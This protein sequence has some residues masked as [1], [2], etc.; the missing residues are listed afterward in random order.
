MNLTVSV[1]KV[2]IFR[3]MHW[4]AHF[5]FSQAAMC[6]GLKSVGTICYRAYGSRSPA[7]HRLDHIF[8]RGISI[9]CEKLKCAL[10]WTKRAGGICIITFMLTI[11]SDRLGTCTISDSL[12]TYL[13]YHHFLSE[14]YN[15]ILQKHCHFFEAFTTKFNASPIRVQHTLE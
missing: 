3:V 5:R 7:F 10:H 15:I 6:N 12:G 1:M 13:T 14:L 2:Q 9:S 11:A 8:L 4:R